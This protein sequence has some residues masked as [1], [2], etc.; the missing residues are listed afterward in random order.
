MIAGLAI[1]GLMVLLVGE[2]RNRLFQ[3]LEH[4][5]QFDSLSSEVL[6]SSERNIGDQYVTATANIIRTLKTDEYYY[7]RRIFALLFVRPI[8]RA[9]WPTKY[10]DLGLGWMASGAGTHGLKDYE[11]KEMVGIEVQKGSAVGFIADLF[12]EFSWFGI[13]VCWLLGRLFGGA[14][15]KSLLLGGGHSLF[16]FVLCFLSIYLF[17]QSLGAWLEKVLMLGIPLWLIWG[18]IQRDR[19]AY[20]PMQEEYYSTD[21]SG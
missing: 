7:G 14:Y 21:A 10:E 13:I 18:Y 5:I 6:G 19:T 2:N 15:T 20:Q 3:P 1:V 8:P 16:Y 4:Q 17:S 9:I 11:W 12:M